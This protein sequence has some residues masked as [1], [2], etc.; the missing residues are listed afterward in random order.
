M[1][2]G[3]EVAGIER[4]KRPEVAVKPRL[5]LKQLS[6]PADN[7]FA[8]ALADIDLTVHAGEVVGIAG[9]AG[10][11]QQEFFDAHLRRAAG[12]RTRT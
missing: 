3:A 12:R 5:V 11:G 1:M 7:P 8:T 6:L 10:N 9:V 2:V 4:P